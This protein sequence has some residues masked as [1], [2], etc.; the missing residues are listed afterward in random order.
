MTV[1]GDSSLL[2]TVLDSLVPDH[3]VFSRKPLT[4]VIHRASH[5]LGQDA[6]LSRGDGVIDQYMPFQVPS[7]GILMV[8]HVAL[9]PSV[10]ALL[11]FSNVTVSRCIPCVEVGF[12]KDSNR[13]VKG[14]HDLPPRVFGVTYLRL[15]LVLAWEP[16]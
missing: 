2:I 11:M 5:V 12:H 13:R 6:H 14:R 9:K 15:A 4:T 7:L 16:Q 3:I 8:A 10:V 1:T